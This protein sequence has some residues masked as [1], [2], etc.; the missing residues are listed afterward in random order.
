[1][2][3]FA[4]GRQPQKQGAE[5]GLAQA[6]ENIRAPKGIGNAVQLPATDPLSCSGMAEPLQVGSN[7]VA[8]QS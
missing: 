3:T 4:A 7:L 6:G 8:A 5:Q 1:M 2:L